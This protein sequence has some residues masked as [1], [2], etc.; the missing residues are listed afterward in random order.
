MTQSSAVLRQKVA[1]MTK[2]KQN[3]GRKG[4]QRPATVVMATLDRTTTLS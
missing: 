2:Q 4:F 1:R 3:I